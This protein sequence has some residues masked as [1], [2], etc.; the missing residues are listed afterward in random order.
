MVKEYK[1]I[2]GKWVKKD[3]KKKEQ[4]SLAYLL[5]IAAETMK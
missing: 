1:L 3:A 2:N 5:S 4:K